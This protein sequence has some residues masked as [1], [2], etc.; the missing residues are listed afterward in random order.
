MTD[1]IRQQ[2]YLAKNSVLPAWSVSFRDDPTCPIGVR[3]DLAKNMV[4]NVAVRG[5]R[6]RNDFDRISIFKRPIYNATWNNKTERWED[7]VKQGE[8][9]F[10]LT[11]T[12]ENREVVYRCQ[13]F[14]YR[15][16]MGQK[17]GPVFVSV[18]AQPLAGYS[19]APMFK[20]GTDF[21]FR[22]SFEL[23]LD[24]NGIPHSRAGLKPFEGTPTELVSHVR[25]YGSKAR[26]ETT[27]EW[28]SDYLLLLVEFGRRDLHNVMHGYWGHRFYIEGDCD[29]TDDR[30]FYHFTTDDAFPF[31]VNEQYLL[32]YSDYQ[33]EPI[34]KFVVVTLR[35]IAPRE[36]GLYMLDFGLENMAHLVDDCIEFEIKL[37]PTRTGEAIR[38]VT[39]ASS[40]TAGESRD[41]IAPIVWRGK[42][43][44]WGNTASFMCDMIYQVQENRIFFPYHLDSISHFDGTPN[45][46]YTSCSVKGYSLSAYA[47][48]FITGFSQGTLPHIL[49]PTSSTLYNPEKYWSTHMWV[50]SNT[51][52]A[53]K[54]LRMGGNSRSVICVNHGSFELIEDNKV[55][56]GFGGRLVLEGGTV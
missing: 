36:D 48:Y 8:A 49:I 42:E 18:S 27:A 2:Q 38:L 35:S 9:D 29:R 10:T 46:H 16:E 31:T 32:S 40:G 56:E 28:F 52:G 13:P 1:R 34:S 12:K 39:S 37:L 21:V 19:L 47:V 26:T 7:L 45:K 54:F 53:T 50:D 14:W 30:E 51:V 33:S 4:A 24:E 25:S 15:L 55:G 5:E 20:N 3:E 22:P 17:Y 41:A 6:V 44:P 11:P 23:A 43:N